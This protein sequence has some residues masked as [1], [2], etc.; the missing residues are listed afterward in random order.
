M[1]VKW[2][3][4]D[5]SSW[6]RIQHEVTAVLQECFC[7]HWLSIGCSVHAAEEMGQNDL[8]TLECVLAADNGLPL[9]STVAEAC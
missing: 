7:F 5:S 8:D 3:D 2:C 4:V 9:H 1:S 6:L